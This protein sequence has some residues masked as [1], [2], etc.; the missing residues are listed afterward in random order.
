MREFSIP[1]DPSMYITLILTLS[2][3]LL[4]YNNL[5]AVEVILDFLQ[6]PKDSMTVKERI[7]YYQLLGDV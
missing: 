5:K 3:N 6:I 2:I 7:T 4:L 1:L